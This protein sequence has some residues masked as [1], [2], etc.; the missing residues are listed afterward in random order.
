[1]NITTSTR[2]VKLVGNAKRDAAIKAA[3]QARLATRY[4]INSS[5]YRQATSKGA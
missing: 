3:H 1:M 5:E 2:K 4:G